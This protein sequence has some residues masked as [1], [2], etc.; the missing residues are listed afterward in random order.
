MTTPV[1]IAGRVSIARLHGAACWHCGAV[2]RGLTPA[3]EVVLEG[4]VWP[5][6]SCGCTPTTDLESTMPS[7][8]LIPLP[9]PA[10]LSSAQQRGAG[11]VWCG[12]TL[13]VR[14]AV[15]LGPRHVDVHG[16]R[17]QWFPRGCRNCW[18]AHQ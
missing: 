13:A 16:C 4:R 15:N 6:V 9:D 7:S 2:T 5:I 10:A 12:I 17:V 18:E 14:N 1:L 11:C 8:A 3:G